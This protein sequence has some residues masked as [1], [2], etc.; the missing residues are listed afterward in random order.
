MSEAGLEVLIPLGVAL[1]A[2]LLIGSERER[3][4]AEA[5]DA[6]LVGGARTHALV[7][8]S[9]ALAM[10]LE[11]M[12]G[13]APVAVG[14]LGLMAWLYAGYRDDVH[15]ERRRGLVPEVGLLTAWL[16]GVTAASDLL[17]LQDRAMAVLGLAV[18]VTAVLRTKPRMHAFIRGLRPD[19]VRAALQFLAVALVMLPLLPDR[20]YGPLDV[21]NPHQIGLMVVL[22]AGLD[23]AGYV[24]VRALGPGRGLGLT[25]LLGGLV[26]STAV[27]LAASGRAREA[28][29]LADGTALAVVTASTI[30][31]PRVLLEV[32]VVNAELLRPL[33]LPFGAMTLT[34]G[35]GAL[36]L[37]LR[38]RG[39]KP[40]S[41]EIRL[42]NPF[43]LG[44]ALKFGLLFALVLFISKAAYEYLGQRGT[45]LAGGLA[46]L[47]DVDAITLS[48]SR[49]AREGLAEQVAVITIALAAASNTLVKAGLALFIGGRGHGL[50][51][52]ASLA[53]ALAVGAV[54][55]ALTLG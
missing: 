54:V 10:L 27:T 37:Y 38:T 41:P 25:G 13:F 45:Y 39:D 48:M 15:K 5:G 47:T 49:L 26:S 35:V 43:E 40:T 31:F 23:F 50:R 46:G 7:A 21:L 24:A 8:L 34:G 2:G 3:A 28:P 44:P 20:T 36:L 55:F 9:G 11:P 12:A 30:M 1:L 17:P 29:A 14:Q 4:P 22:I 19:D 18:V 53:S 33:A 42:V 51:V 16:L 6:S 52:L 32:A